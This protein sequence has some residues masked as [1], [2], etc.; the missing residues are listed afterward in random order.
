M[1]Y[2]PKRLRKDIHNPKYSSPHCHKEYKRIDHFQAHQQLCNDMI[3]SESNNDWGLY[4]DID[5]TIKDE[6]TD[7]ND[8]SVLMN[9][10]K[11]TK[12]T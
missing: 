9:N 8:S 10:D 4:G 12:C 5:M 7:Y 3:G 2:A 11:S 6:Y 1:K